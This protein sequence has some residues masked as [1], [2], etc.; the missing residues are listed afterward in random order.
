[1]N[2]HNIANNEIL[3]RDAGTQELDDI[4]RLIKDAF[5][6]YESF[7]SSPGWQAYVEE[8]TDVRSRLGDSNLIVAELNGRLVGTVT[9][10]L[11]SCSVDQ[12]YLESHPGDQGWPKGWASIR[13]LATR[14]SYRR[15][16]IGRALI[17]ECLLRCRERSISTIGL[18]TMAIMD[19]ARQMYERIGF[20]RVSNF[21]FHPTLNHV[22]MAYCFTI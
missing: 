14:P 1:M 18:H 17:A 7:M 8:I 15:L 4:S 5:Q 22:V 11:E 12:L 9:L 2:D 16:G 6:Q 13:L 20:V 19:I 3:T 10:Y 21:D